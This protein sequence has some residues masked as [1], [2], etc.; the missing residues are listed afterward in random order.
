MGFFSI[1][2]HQSWIDKYH[3]G[4][5]RQA[6]IE[7]SKGIVLDVGCGNKPFYPYIKKRIEQYIGLEHKDSIHAKDKAEILGSADDI[8]LPDN[9]IDTVLLTQ[10]IEHVEDPARVL[11]EIR[12]VLKMKGILIIAWPFL[13][14][15]H[16]E[17]RDF[18]RY[19]A[20]G[21]RHLAKAAGFE[22][23]SLVPVSGFWITWFGFISIYIRGKSL[24]MYLLLY[25]VLLLLKIFC[26]LVQALDRNANAKLKWAWNYYAI[27]K[28]INE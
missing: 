6:I 10:V 13:Y 16:E 24:L 27:L 15:I 28:K 26:M 3:V 19:T 18:Y 23:L 25:P 8:P 2:L 4:L 9:H 14:P 12:R 5:V 17:P 11:K 20:F 1:P 21:I 22:V 7:Y